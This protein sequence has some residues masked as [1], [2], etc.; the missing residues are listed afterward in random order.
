MV[1]VAEVLTLN[2]DGVRLI[3]KRG[4][5]RNFCRLGRLRARPELAHRANYVVN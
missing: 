4:P 3:A 5:K 2:N 1:R